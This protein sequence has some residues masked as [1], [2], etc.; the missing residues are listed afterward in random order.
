VALFILGK[1]KD[2]YTVTLNH[3]EAWAAK[4]GIPWRAIKPHLANTM[5]K[6]REVWPAMLNDMPM[7]D[8]HKEKLKTHWK[9]LQP[10]FRIL[11]EKL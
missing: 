8:N 4:S 6:A 9:N 5:E 7:N 11:R 1:I 2:W 10:D 3:F